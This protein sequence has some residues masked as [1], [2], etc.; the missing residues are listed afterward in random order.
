MLDGLVENLS[1]KIWN[2]K[3]MEA[4]NHAF[5]EDAI[6]HSLFGSSMGIEVMK[7]VV[8]KWLN[9]FPDLHIIHQNLF[10]DGDKVAIQWTATGTHQ[11]A[12]KGYAATGKSVAYKGVTI[13]RLKDDK[14][15]EYW[16]YLDVDNVL[17]QIR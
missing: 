16:T 8:Q 10:L 17:S 6:I 13:Y 14:V 4:I 7:D 9:A 12:F 2:E 3:E 1:Y 11:G 15:I 5:A